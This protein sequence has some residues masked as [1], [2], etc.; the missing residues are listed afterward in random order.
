M[1]LQ[2][3]IYMVQMR[4][5][6][7]WDDAG[8]MVDDLPHR[9][10]SVADAKDEINDEILDVEKAIADGYMDEES[11]RY[12]DDYRVVPDPDPPAEYYLDGTPRTASDI[13]DGMTFYDKYS[14]ALV[15]FNFYSPEVGQIDYGNAYVAFD[16]L[17]PRFGLMSHGAMY[18]ALRGLWSTYDRDFLMDPNKA[19]D[20]RRGVVQIEEDLDLPIG[21][22]FYVGSGEIGSPTQMNINVAFV[23]VPSMNLWGQMQQLTPAQLRSGETMW[24]RVPQADVDNIDLDDI[25]RY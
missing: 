3:P 1:V 22:Y 23:Y 12:L 19:T 15:P 24:L 10:A 13:P 2:Q 9:F 14:V 8:W 11:R 4:F 7:G 17:D 16:K 18:P 6:G 5:L 20:G 21:T 25:I